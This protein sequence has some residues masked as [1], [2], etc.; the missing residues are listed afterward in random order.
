MGFEIMP[1]GRYND[2]GDPVVRS[3]FEDTNN[4]FYNIT[5]EKIQKNLDNVSRIACL[6]LTFI[7]KNNLWNKLIL[8]TDFEE[9][10]IEQSDFIKWWIKHKA[11]DQ[12]RKIKEEQIRREKFEK[13]QEKNQ[14]LAKLS[15]EERKILG[16]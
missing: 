6:A 4:D 3:R 16:L 1:C 11:E 7:E 12:K 9:A 2:S 10:G 13:E 5:I 15:P 14:I 8:E